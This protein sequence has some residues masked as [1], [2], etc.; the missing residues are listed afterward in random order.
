MLFAAFTLPPLMPLFTLRHAIL[1]YAAISISI[2]VAIRADA[3]MPY[4]AMMMLRAMLI[5]MLAAADIDMLLDGYHMLM[6]PP[7]D[8]TTYADTP[9]TATPHVFFT[10]MMIRRLPPLIYAPLFSLLMLFTPP[11]LRH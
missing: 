6:L 4:A 1:R 2:F 8:I 3:A 10:L 11:L 7:S 9:P 5:L